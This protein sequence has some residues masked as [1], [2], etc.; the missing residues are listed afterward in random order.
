MS[1][2]S[3]Q[4]MGKVEE[5]EVGKGGMGGLSIHTKFAD[6]RRAAPP[7]P[8]ERAE[9]RTSPAAPNEASCAET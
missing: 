3:E 2:R 9:G 1:G 4:E 8:T 7:G 6:S 5:A